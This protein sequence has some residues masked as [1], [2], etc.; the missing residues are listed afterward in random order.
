LMVNTINER[1]SC[2]SSNTA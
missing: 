2:F 1:R